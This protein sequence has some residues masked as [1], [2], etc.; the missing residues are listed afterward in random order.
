MDDESRESKYERFNRVF[1]RAVLAGFF[2]C[3]LGYVSNS[4]SYK[5]TTRAL[6]TGCSVENVRQIIEKNKNRMFGDSDIGRLCHYL[7]AGIGEES[8]FRNY[9]K[10]NSPRYKHRTPDFC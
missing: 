1:R 9:E 3:W 2:V 7:F 10:E 4:M 5:D 8:A 6:N